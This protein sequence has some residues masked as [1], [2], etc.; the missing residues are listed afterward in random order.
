MVTMRETKSQPILVSLFSINS[1]GLSIV[2]LI[3]QGLEALP[4]IDSDQPGAGF[5]GSAFEHELFSSF[6]FSFLEQCR[7]RGQLVHEQRAF[8]CISCLSDP[9]ESIRGRATCWLWHMGFA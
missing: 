8:D 7:Q 5:D 9:H 2:P 6:L 1:L 3:G 4:D